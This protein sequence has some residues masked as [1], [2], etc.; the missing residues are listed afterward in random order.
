MR[1]GDKLQASPTDDSRLF[2]MV[3]GNKIVDFYLGTTNGRWKILL[4]YPVNF[5]SVCPT[6]LIAFSDKYAEFQ[7]RNC[8]LFGIS[9]DSEYSH[10]AWCKTPKHHGGVTGLQFPLVSDIRKDLSRQFGVLN[11][12]GVA[13]RGLFIIDPSNTIRII[14]INDIPIGRNVDETIRLLDALQYCEETKA[15]C[16]V[17]WKRGDPILVSDPHEAQIYFQDKYLNSKKPTD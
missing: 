3:I 16:P 13:Y 2:K 6:E 5:T 1:I 7:E 14:Q 11:A 10:L 8:D 12:E 17:N 9:V 4:F 15:M